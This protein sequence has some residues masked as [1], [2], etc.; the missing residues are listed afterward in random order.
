MGS[1]LEVLL[2]NWTGK[3]FI[4][5]KGIECV[6]NES[7]VV[8]T[9]GD[10]VMESCTTGQSVLVGKHLGACYNSNVLGTLAYTT[11]HGLNKGKKALTPDNHRHIAQV[12]TDATFWSAFWC[13]C[14]THSKTPV[15]KQYMF[16]GEPRWVR[17]LFFPF[18][19]FV[20]F[21]HRVEGRQASAKA[22][23]AVD[24]LV[25]ILSSR[26]EISQSG[27]ASFFL[28][29]WVSWTRWIEFRPWHA[30]VW[31]WGGCFKDGPSCIGYTRS[32]LSLALL[33]SKTVV[34]RSFFY[35]V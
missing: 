15:W 4:E 22:H 32:V 24:H 1:E 33:C 18:F 9:W 30:C 29:I 31:F 10:V 23:E 11:R 5:W 19:F 14:H 20:E 7:L 3:Q 35:R 6:M 27:I 25:S 16:G 21:F 26:E 8:G 13:G 34:W 17:F 2:I 28:W 12:N